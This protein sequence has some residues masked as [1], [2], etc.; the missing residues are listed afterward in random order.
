MTSKAIALDQLTEQNL[1]Q[2]RLLNKVIFP[3]RYNERFYKDLF[4]QDVALSRLAYCSSSAVGTVC[5]RLEKD[6]KDSGNKRSKLYIMTLGVLAP[7][8]RLGI[9][10]KLLEYVLDEICANKKYK[11]LRQVY[12][13]VQVSN[14][15]AIEFYRKHG[16]EVTERIEGYYRRI[17]PADCFILTRHVNQ[18]T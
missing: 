4:K 11:D 2:L 10:S 15:A 7:Y 1:G 13:H 3:V 14:D 9:G 6:A 18:A 16:F 12:L 8:R 17:E 5:C